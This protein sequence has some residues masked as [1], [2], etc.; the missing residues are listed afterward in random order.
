MSEKL[1]ELEVQDATRQL[2]TF[3]SNREQ[4]DSDNTRG[5]KSKLDMANSHETTQRPTNKSRRSEIRDLNATPRYGK[6]TIESALKDIRNDKD[7]SNE[8]KQQQQEYV[9]AT[10]IQYSDL[11]AMRKSNPMLQFQSPGGTR[12]HAL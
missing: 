7:F 10:T 5:L 12:L 6:P 9:A 2:D 11:E 3:L 8:S 4:D 1:P